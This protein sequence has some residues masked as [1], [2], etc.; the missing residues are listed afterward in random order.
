M[1]LIIIVNFLHTLHTWIRIPL[2]WSVIRL[3]LLVPIQN[4]ANEGGDKGHAGFGACDGLGETEEEGKVAVDAVVALEFAGGLDA[5]PGGGDFDE[6][7]VFGDAKGGVEGDELFGLRRNEMN[8]RIRSDAVDMWQLTLA[9]VPSLLKER[10]ASTSV[11]TRPGMIFK[12]SFP[13]STSC[14]HSLL[15]TQWR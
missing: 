11:E 2:I 5:F 7:A 12:I 13:N 3:I 1:L 9:F 10:R 8:I 14:H 4:T 6:D 15:N